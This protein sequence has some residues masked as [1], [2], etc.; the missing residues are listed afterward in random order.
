MAQSPLA[1]FIAQNIRAA[2]FNSSENQSRQIFG[3]EY[4]RALTDLVAREVKIGKLNYSKCKHYLQ[5]TLLV[6]PNV[7]LSHIPLI[8]HL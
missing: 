1:N 5:A 4:Q 7:I 6:K 2:K 8:V 3:S